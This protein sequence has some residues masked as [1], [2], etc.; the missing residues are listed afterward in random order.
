MTMNN[1]S[2]IIT[3][4]EYIASYGKA[5]KSVIEH[6]KQCGGGLCWQYQD[7]DHIARLIGDDDIVTEFYLTFNNPNLK[8]EIKKIIKYV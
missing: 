7:I 3:A 8:V 1:Y 6:W 2:C 5:Y 4:N